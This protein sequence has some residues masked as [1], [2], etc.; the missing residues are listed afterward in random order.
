MYSCRCNIRVFEGWPLGKW[1]AKKNAPLWRGLPLD[2]MILA[3]QWNTSL[4]TI[5]VKHNVGNSQA[6]LLSSLLSCFSVMLC[7]FTSHESTRSARTL[8]DTGAWG[9]GLLSSWGWA[10]SQH[11]S[12]CF[13]ASWGS[14]IL[15][16]QSWFVGFFF[17]NLISEIFIYSEVIKTFLF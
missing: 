17:F 6:K 5:P 1:T 9:Q 8:P 2:S 3:W 14:Y 16:C 7:D 15:H 11:R 4:L 12:C 10:S 13:L